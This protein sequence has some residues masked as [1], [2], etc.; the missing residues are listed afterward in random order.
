MTELGK[1][2]LK[3]VDHGRSGQQQ[4]HVMSMGINCS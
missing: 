2:E 4:G 3:R 1:D